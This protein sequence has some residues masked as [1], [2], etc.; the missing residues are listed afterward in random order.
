M[1]NSEVKIHAHILWVQRPYAS[2]IGRT[3][4][5]LIRKMPTG[6]KSL[7]MGKLCLKMGKD[8]LRAK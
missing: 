4:K 2:V 6:L 3:P 5:T 7:M 8:V 1:P